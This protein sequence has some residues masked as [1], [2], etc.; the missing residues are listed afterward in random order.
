MNALNILN[1]S[2]AAAHQSETDKQ[3]WSV[4]A[5]DIRLAPGLFPPLLKFKGQTLEKVATQRD[6]DHDITSV[7]Y[8]NKKRDLTLVVFND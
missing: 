8:S 1:V 2:D 3:R 5:S 4:E 7:E 6:E